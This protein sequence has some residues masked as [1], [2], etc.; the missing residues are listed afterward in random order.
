M[1]AKICAIFMSLFAAMMTMF[2]PLPDVDAMP[3]EADASFETALRFVV[4]SDSHVKKYG[5]IG[6]Q[7]IMKMIKTGY[8]A[9]E[10]DA[11]HNTLDAAV[12]VGDITN[13]GWPHTFWSVGA[14]INKVLKEETDM[15]AVAA[16]NHDSYLGRISRCYVSGLSG[17]SADF[18]KIINGYHFI[19]LS[20]SPTSI[21][22]YTNAQLKWLDAQLAAAV[23]DDPAKPVFVFQ[24]EHI[25]DTVYGSYPED[26]WGVEFFT[27]ILS[28]YPQ[29][30]DISGH[31][32]YP[33]NDPRAI[34]QG[35]FTAINDGGLAY[36][37]FTIDGAKSQHPESSDNMAHCLLVE[38]DTNQN[39]KVRVCDLNANA[40]L[41]EY[42]IDNVADPVKT[43]YAPETRKAESKAPEFT[44]EPSCDLSG[45]TAAI[46]VPAAKTEEDDVVF[47]YRAVIRDENGAVL[48]SFRKLGQYYKGIA[49]GNTVFSYTFENAGN[50]T[51]SCI[52]ED[53]WGHVT[54]TDLN[55]T[56]G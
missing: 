27:D 38:V 24:H 55:V 21:I 31:S 2:T 43:K 32:H 42:L 52:A 9:A 7:R 5:D 25:Y 40:V 47:I 1:F 53:A 50:Y 18:H 28:K 14:S 44:A 23:A 37:E 19:G 17:D 35:A 39:V 8:A 11:N 26:T 6:C 45:N 15:L 4:S 29:V 49:D 54:S 56:V 51:V 20:A 22:H 36:Y 10:A 3:V 46:T 34:W 13:T 30:I 16:K 33:A 12:L 48:K 41:A